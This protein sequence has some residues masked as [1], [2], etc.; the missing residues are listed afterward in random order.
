MAVR[1]RHTFGQSACL[2]R[3]V[4]TLT[5]AHASDNICMRVETQTKLCLHPC[6]KTQLGSGM[7]AVLSPIGT[8]AWR[9]P[10]V[11]EV[12]APERKKKRYA[13]QQAACITELRRREDS[14]IGERGGRIKFRM[15]WNIKIANQCRRCSNPKHSICV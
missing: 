13:S 8:G 11:V 3:C 10:A 7:D 15:L 2:H 12:L 5:K 14:A 9:F 6:E 1:L 4:R